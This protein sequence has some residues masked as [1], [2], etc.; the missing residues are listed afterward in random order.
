MQSALWDRLQC[1][2]VY[3]FVQLL[4]CDHSP[5]TKWKCVVLLSSSGCMLPCETNFVLNSNFTYPAESL[6]SFA[7]QF[8][9]CVSCK[10]HEEV[11]HVFVVWFIYWICYGN[12]RHSQ[13]P[14]VCICWTGSSIENNTLHFYQDTFFNVPV[15]F[16]SISDIWLAGSHFATESKYNRKRMKLNKDEIGGLEAVRSHSFCIGIS[17]GGKCKIDKT[18]DN[19]SPT[20]ALNVTRSIRAIQIDRI[21]TM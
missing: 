15:L 14:V 7:S 20:E 4:R 5:K 13:H 1:V 12:L 2:G 17:K 9:I 18:V 16:V 11:F 6:C 21:G 8:I 10:Y 19:P 3:Q